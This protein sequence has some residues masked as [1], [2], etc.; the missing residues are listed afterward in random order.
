MEEK[1]TAP[2]NRARQAGWLRGGA[3]RVS[4]V[5]FL[6]NKEWEKGGEKGKEGGE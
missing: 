2:Q 3:K 4:Q 5:I 6:N 1:G